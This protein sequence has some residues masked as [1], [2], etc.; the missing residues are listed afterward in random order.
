MFII[1]GHVSALRYRSWLLH[2]STK[3][4]TRDSGWTNDGLLKQSCLDC[5]RS[6]QN[7]GIL[8]STHPVSDLWWT[9]MLLYV[10]HVIV[11]ACLCRLRACI[12]PKLQIHAAY[13]ARTHHIHKTTNIRVIMQS[14]CPSYWLH[15]HSTNS[16]GTNKSLC[17][18]SL[19]T[20]VFNLTCNQILFLVSRG[21]PTVH[22]C[23]VAE[24]GRGL[25]TP[26][27]TP[28]DL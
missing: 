19:G 22:P 20:V 8:R 5:V 13:R 11:S 6:I 17:F 16:T 21:P 9:F 23:T 24:S 1:R 4:W 10:V 25:Y 27:T 28:L 15:F 2:A 7:I 14:Y 3:R 12:L 18:I 26:W